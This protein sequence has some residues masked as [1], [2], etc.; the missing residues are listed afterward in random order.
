MVVEGEEAVAV[1]EVVAIE[2]IGTA[3][4]VK[5][6]HTLIFSAFFEKK[7]ANP[8]LSTNT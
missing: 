8:S 5:R 1:A 4:Q 6:K 7:L 2:M 3:A